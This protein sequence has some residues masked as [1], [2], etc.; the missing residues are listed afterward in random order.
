MSIFLT[1]AE[2]S[3]IINF[4]KNEATGL[5]SVCYV[6]GYSRREALDFLKNNMSPSEFLAWFYNVNERSTFKMPVAQKDV[7]A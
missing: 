6:T 2:I 4:A 1:E 5:A 7:W 3:D